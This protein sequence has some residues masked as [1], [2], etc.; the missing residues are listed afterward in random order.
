MKND[1]ASCDSIFQFSKFN[2]WNE[3]LARLESS[4]I[5]E[6]WRYNS[7]RN[8]ESNSTNPILENYVHHTFRRLIQEYRAA[9]TI[10]EKKNIIFHND[11][12]ACIN[13]GL[14]TPNYNMLYLLFYPNTNTKASQPYFCFGVVEGSSERLIDIDVL[15]RRATYLTDVRDLVYDCNLELRINAEHML[16]DNISRFPVDLQDKPI[17]CTLFLGA[18]EMAKKRVQ[19]NYKLAVPTYHKNEIC[20]LLPI[21]LSADENKTDLA[22]A[23]RRTEKFYIGKTCLTLDMAYN[24]ARL[25]AKPFTDWLLP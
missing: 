17:L 2:N 15:P 11:N 3:T 25:I 23:V 10:E 20:L 6:N 16:R 21:C 7:P 1:I 4:A 8:S 24:D 13:T 19:A 14:F 9:Q 5:Q 22:L 12:L 18:I